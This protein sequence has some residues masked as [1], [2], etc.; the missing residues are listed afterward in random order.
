MA[1]AHERRR[2]LVDS[3]ARRARA[4]GHARRQPLEERELMLSDLATKVGDRAG[5]SGPVVRV[6]QPLYAA[7]LNARYGRSGLPWSING[8]PLR[9]D[10]SVRHMVPRENERPLFD[11]LRA[12]IKPGDVVFDI[13]AF[14]GTYALM[15]ARWA[16]DSGRVVAFEPSS[17]SFAVLTRHMRMNGL[18]GTRVDARQAAVGRTAGSRELITF[19]DE[20]YRNQIAPATGPSNQVTVDALT[21]DAVSKEL[22]RP[23]D[24]IRMDVQGLEF[25]VLEGARDA[26]RDA[27]GRMKIV[28]EMHPEQWPDFG[29]R[30]ED[31][32]DRFA[33]CGLKARALTPA[34]PLFTQSGHAVLEPLS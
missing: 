19:D 23:P 1:A 33:A 15:E 34:E 17:F 24:W 12:N 26:I 30:P 22:G 10:P 7:W 14:L 5:R 27:R 18:A 6:L 32:H 4:R 28:A 11:F 20:P 2:R 13:G 25:E 21:V 8:E 31:A 16:G 9:I 3:R 29:I